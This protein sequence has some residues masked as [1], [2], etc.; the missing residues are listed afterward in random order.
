MEIDFTGIT[1]EPVS[2]RTEQPSPQ[3]KMEIFT[4][5]ND[6]YTYVLPD[7]Y[8][9]TS[10]RLCAACKDQRERASRP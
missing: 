4:D 8:A 2:G 9:D 7:Y 5:G 1:K 10:T 6:D 3:T